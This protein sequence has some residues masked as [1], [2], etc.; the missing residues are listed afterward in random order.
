MTSSSVLSR[1]L[2]L[3]LT[4]ATFVNFLGS[5]ALGPFLP[6][7][8]ADLETTVSLVGQVPALVTF[9]AALLGLV[10][11]P[12]ADQYGYSRTLLIGLLAAT[13]SSLTVGLA[14]SFGV[15]LLVTI[16][17]A[18]GRAAVQPAAQAIVAAR[19]TEEASRRHAMSRV[20]MGNSGAA[21]LG[22]PVLTFVAAYGGW[23]L[24]FMSLVLLGVGS[25]VM[26]WRTVPEDEA[27]S[28]G[29]LPIRSV[30][31]SYVPL[32]RHRA[33]LCMIG[34]TLIGNMGIWVIWSYL[35][36]LLVEVHGFSVQDVGWVYFVG[37]SGV[38]VGTILSGTRIGAQPRTLMVTS[39][40]IAAVLLA[41]AMLLP[42]SGMAVAG[43][44][45][46]TLVFQGMYGVPN[47]M[48]LTAESPAGRAT[49]MTLNN[50]AISLATALGGVVGGITIAQGGYAALGLVGPIFPLVGASIIWLTRPKLLPG[51]ALAD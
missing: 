47:L 45:S 3:A 50:S 41:C 51:L 46:L 36:A 32:L 35:A 34:A 26:L 23:R 6:Q 30:L 21:I 13:V 27:S 25:L 17:G 43:M 31:A 49:T 22:I 24:A 14:P 1:W 5:L 2:V 48:V 11:G 38:M 16:L 28:S 15:L 20:S 12:L 18:I 37:G 40:A 42:L 7:V 39:R 19:F 44:L 10:I 29:R 4:A 9:I 33:T 8:A